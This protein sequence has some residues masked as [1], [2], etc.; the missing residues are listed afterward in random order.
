[1]MTARSHPFCPP[2]PGLLLSP[3]QAPVDTGPSPRPDKE[4]PGYSFTVEQTWL[5]FP[6]D[7]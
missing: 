5:E 7:I 6:S 1:M 4:L 3:N 2:Q